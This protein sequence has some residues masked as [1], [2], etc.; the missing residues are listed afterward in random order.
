MPFGAFAPLPIRLG[1]SAE[2]GLTPEQH[3]RLC[4]DLL[5]A[6]FVAPLAT[7][8]FTK[9]GATVT[10]ESYVGQNGAG[11]AHAPVASA[12]AT[13]FSGFGWTSQSFTDPYGV[14][15]PIRVRQ[16]IV[17][18]HGSTAA[19]GTGLLSL[20]TVVVVATFNQAGAGVDCRATVRVW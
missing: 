18:P 16:V 20:G 1:G 4:A 9:S 13:G 12:G 17:T 8:T 15:Y 11:L 14:L 3:A 2:E 5:A 19:I 7:W 6:K 10:V